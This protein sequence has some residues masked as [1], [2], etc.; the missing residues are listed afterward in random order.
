MDRSPLTRREEQILVSELRQAP[1]DGIA[2][3]N[4][5]LGALSILSLAGVELDLPPLTWLA[6][7]WSE[8]CLELWTLA[9]S[10][11]PLEI[12]LSPLATDGVTLVLLLGLMFLRG[13]RSGYVGLNAFSFPAQDFIARLIYLVVVGGLAIKGRRTLSSIPV[14]FGDRSVLVLFTFAAMLVG[15]YIVFRAY[16]SLLRRWRIVPRL[17][18]H[19]WLIAL[20]PVVVLL[21]TSNLPSGLAAS[22]ADQELFAMFFRIAL[23]LAQIV[24][25]LG[26]VFFGFPLAFWYPRI[27]ASMA[28]AVLALLILDGLWRMGPMAEANSSGVSEL[29]SDGVPLIEADE[30]FGALPRQGTV[31]R[32]P[33]PLTKDEIQE[34]MSDWVDAVARAGT[35]GAIRTVSRCFDRLHEGSS[36]PELHRCLIVDR[37]G[38]AHYELIARYRNVVTEEGLA[39]FT[40]EQGMERA[41]T[42]C[43]LLGIDAE[44]CGQVV[45]G[46]YVI[47]DPIAREFDRENLDAMVQKSN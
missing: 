5:V 25:I 26:I 15:G 40:D 13:H 39:F 18:E 32:V 10:W 17:L 6:E 2:L 7:N 1:R 12:S 8:L 46:Q 31:D 20:G 42:S 38:Q 14:L 36:R 43:A 45:W 22:P 29:T 37:Y 34:A 4:S 47:A 3:A 44:T 28:L 33:G 27:A 11:L 19:P 41:A 16:V 9:L 21:V 35:L 24:A 23:A 30:A